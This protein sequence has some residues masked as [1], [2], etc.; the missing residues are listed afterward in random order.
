M[1]ETKSKTPEEAVNSFISRMSE[2]VGSGK[3]CTLSSED[4]KELMNEVKEEIFEDTELD[5]L[6]KTF[7]EK[8]DEADDAKS[9]VIAYLQDN[10]GFSEDA[11]ELED[12]C[13]YVYSLDDQKVKRFIKNAGR[14][15]A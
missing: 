12:S 11:D 8:L 14:S 6:L 2:K 5:N 9:D 1:F 10:Y 7:Y 3:Q 13:S 4:I 15:N